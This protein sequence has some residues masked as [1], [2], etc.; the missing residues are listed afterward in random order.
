LIVIEDA[1]AWESFLR[2]LPAGSSLALRPDFATERVAVVGP[3]AGMGG[4]DSFRVVESST[5]LVIV[6]PL[7]LEERAV[8]TGGCAVVIPADGRTVDLAQDS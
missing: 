2:R 7:T 4:C 3:A 6:W 8:P 1:V 5:R